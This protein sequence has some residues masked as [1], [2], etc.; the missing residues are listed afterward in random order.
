MITAKIYEP[1]IL[2]IR[3]NFMIDKDVHRLTTM[4]QK[5]NHYT[6]VFLRCAKKVYN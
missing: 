5:V 6:K 2:S 4:Y 3:K 1:E